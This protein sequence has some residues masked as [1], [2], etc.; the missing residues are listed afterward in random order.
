M[1]LQDLALQ[2]GRYFSSMG[3]TDYWRY[4]PGYTYQKLL[5]V[6]T[7]RI[8]GHGKQVDCV[9]K[10]FIFV[11][12]FPEIEVRLGISAMIEFDNLD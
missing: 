7:T 8:N 10:F 5:R 12:N 1:R 4:L 11:T 9:L 2:G 3:S 6:N